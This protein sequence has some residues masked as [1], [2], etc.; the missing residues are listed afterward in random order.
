MCLCQDLGSDIIGKETM[1]L[2]LEQWRM[3]QGIMHE[4]V[5]VYMTLSIYDFGLKNLDIFNRG[6]LILNP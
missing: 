1:F 2:S 4:F 6:H 5:G 3:R